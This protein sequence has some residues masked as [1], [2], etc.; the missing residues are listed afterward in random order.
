[1]TTIA[2]LLVVV[3]PKLASLSLWLWVAVGGAFLI[4]LAMMI[5]RKVTDAEGDQHRVV[6]LIWRGYR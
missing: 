1:V 5:E 2:T 6:E 3:G 4:G